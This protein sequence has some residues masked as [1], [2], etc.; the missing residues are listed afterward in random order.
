MILEPKKIKSATEV[1]DIFLSGVGPILL[2]EYDSSTQ[3][4]RAL[5][6]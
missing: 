1:V 2:R 3:G 6:L 4:M 5:P